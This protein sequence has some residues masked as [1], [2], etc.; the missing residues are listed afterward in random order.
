M[1]GTSLTQVARMAGW[2]TAKPR[3]YRSENEASLHRPGHSPDLNKSVLLTGWPT[4]NTMG[5]GQTSRGGDR[6]DEKLMGGLASLAAWPTPMAGTPAQKGYNEAGNSD[7]SRKMVALCRFPAPSTDSG[8]QPIGYLLGP[9]GW[10]TVPASGQL[11]AA[12]SRWLMGLPK[13]WD[14]CGVTAMAS[15]RKSR[16]R[17]SGRTSRKGP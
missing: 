10:E 9:N 14:D 13:E 5:G 2:P 15:L 11:N 6:I 7:S 3:D 8:D 17:S 16:R 12:H 1:S 4:P